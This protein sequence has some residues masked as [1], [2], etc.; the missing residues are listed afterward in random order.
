MV[1]RREVTYSGKTPLAS[2]MSPRAS[3]N[4]YIIYTRMPD[5]TVYC[6]RTLWN[7][8]RTVWVSL[9]QFIEGLNALYNFTFLIWNLYLTGCTF[10]QIDSKK[11]EVAQTFCKHFLAQL[12]KFILFYKAPENCFHKQRHVLPPQKAQGC[13]CSNSPLS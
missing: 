5:D 9:S 11:R 6:I 8:L 4:V 13:F 1:T 2:R 10:F 7:T 12:V 3:R